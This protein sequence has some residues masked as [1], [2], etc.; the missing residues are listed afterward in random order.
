M[1][2]LQ[3]CTL[4]KISTIDLKSYIIMT[5]CLVFFLNMLYPDLKGT[6]FIWDFWNIKGGSL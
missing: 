5:N 4:W 2:L 3:F 6:P 1:A